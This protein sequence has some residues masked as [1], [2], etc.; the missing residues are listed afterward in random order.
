MTGERH[1]E[2]ILNLAR[3]FAYPPTPDLAPAVLAHLPSR[4][5]RPPRIRPAART[6]SLLAVMLA[7]LLA[8]PSARAAVLEI[9]EVG[10]VRILLGS[11]QAP[12]LAAPS[13]TPGVAGA[14]FDLAGRVTLQEAR[15]QFPYPIRLPGF[16]ADIGEPDL[17][18]LQDLEGAAVILIWLDPDDP[19]QFRFSLQ[20]FTDDS[21][22]WK[23]DPALLGRPEVN[24]REAYW[25]RGPYLILTE[26]GGQGASR[27]VE[28]Y[29]LIWA[30]GDLTYRL[31]GDL[32]LEEALQIAESLR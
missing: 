10:I 24:G 28:G 17:V 27:L 7:L 2:Q 22:I 19:S 1:E 23:L 26:S 9:L 18:Y 32:T 25:T 21:H 12:T 20:A 4:L 6:L 15:A 14:T 30:D 3:G 5:Q 29:A 11:P 16:P 31:E 8:V 13:P